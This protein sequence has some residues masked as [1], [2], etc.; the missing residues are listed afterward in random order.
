MFTMRKS[1]SMFIL[2]IMLASFLAGCAPKPDPT[3]TPDPTPQPDPTPALVPSEVLMEAAIDFMSNIPDNVI[4]APDVALGLMD[5]NPDAIFWIDMRSAEDYA[6]GHIAG[7][8][9]LPYAKTGE[10]L[11]VIPA[12]RQVIFQCYSG[13]TSAQTTALLQ[14]LGYN[15]VSFRGGMNFGWAPLELGE[16][17]LET[18]ANDLP[19]VKTP[20]LDERGQIIWDAVVAYFTDSNYV[21]APAAL[22]DLVVENPDAIMVLDIR[23]A[24]DFAKGHIEGAVH[25]AY[26]EV[27]QNFDQLPTNR[28]IY[29]VCYTG[30]T[31]G[32]T[33]G[34]LR[35]AGYNAF[36]LNRGMAGWDAAELPKVTE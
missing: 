4:M 6:K 25:I 34:A 10:L 2:I 15:A 11:G 30:Q 17:S 29:V 26:R 27:G 9:N 16:D 24:E 18:T 35:L 28:P 14:M 7:A 8:V 1:F 21:T 3:P 23:S 36:S 13:Q 32:I 33:M 20:E 31:A 5:E 22:N 12:N 19:E